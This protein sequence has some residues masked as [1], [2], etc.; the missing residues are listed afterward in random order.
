MRVFKTTYKDRHGRTRTA[1]KWYIEFRDHRE[2]IR[3]LPAF[4]DRKQ[5]EAFGRNCEKLVAC[6]LAGE[7]PSGDL[8][9]WV[10][11][12]SASIR[13]KLAKLDLLDGRTLA[14][15]K[16]LSEHVAEFEA[17][18]LAK[19]NVK[20]HVR[21]TVKHVQ[22]VFNGCRFQQWS[23]IAASKVQ[24]FMAKLRESKDGKPGL[25]IQT[26]NY[27]LQSVRQFC[28]W[29]VRDGRASESPVEHLQRQNASTD[30][31]RQRRPLS[32]DEL[33][34]LLTIT[35]SGPER[36]EISGRERAML[37]RLAVETGLRANELRSLTANSFDLDA[38][39]ATVEVAAGY[40]KRRRNDVLPL[41]PNTVELLRDHL[42]HKLPD[43]PAFRLP[44]RD[45]MAAMLRADL[46]AARVAW[47][48][49]AP[50][51]SE[52]RQKR[53]QS[54]FL[55]EVDA[56]G[57]VVDFHSLRHTFI[58]NLAAS[59]VHPKVAQELARHSTITLTMDRYTHS[60]WESMTAALER[61]PDL[62]PVEQ[63]SQLAT[64]TD[65][66]AVLADCLARKGAP[67]STSVH[68]NAPKAAGGTTPNKA[69]NPGKNRN[70]PGESE[71]RAAGT[72]TP[73]QQ[74]MSLLL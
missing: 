44:R 60:A 64:G 26:V 32:A 73:N 17:A 39:P 47:I 30:V 53:E 28:R 11:S 35:R 59:G 2:V 8:G 71:S 52:L 20:Q 13:T 55:A 36:R 6:R 25:S 50:E 61:L 67:K 9:R 4:T 45:A 70:S 58:T 54:D 49:E 74:I 40:S 43:A 37:Y 21:Q 68:P 69:K 10:E 22:T 16:P 65:G 27:Y 5:S 62:T 3:R 56:A 31:R 51:G 14:A 29:M 19:G 38:N 41:R 57:D 12:L 46:A 63:E 15:S 7:K 72:R 23:D 24:T 48:E 18:L 34:W 1:R 42:R 66:P 33:R